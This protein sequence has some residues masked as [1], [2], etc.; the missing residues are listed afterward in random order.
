MT[1]IFA[2]IVLIVGRFFCH[3]EH[4]VPELVTEILTEE[5]KEQDK[6]EDKE[7]DK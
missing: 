6:E 1:Q 7:E 2:I 3:R 5:D 4:I